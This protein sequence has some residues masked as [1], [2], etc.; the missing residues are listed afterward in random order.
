M[1]RLLRLLWVVMG[2]A[3]LVGAQAE[4]Q[5]RP[6][7]PSSVLIID[8]ERLYAESAFGKRVLAEQ[9]AEAAVLA[10]EYRRIEAELSEEE[11]MLTDK[12]SE[13]SPEDFRMVADAFDTRVEGI[14]EAQQQREND[15]IA[16]GDSERQRFFA[17]L[18]PV[19][20][21]VLRES[22]ALVVLEK[23]TVFA[24]SSALDVTDR[25]L[26]QADLI[27]GDGAAENTENGNGEN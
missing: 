27:I 24:S 25:V 11:Q 26:E 7:P 21:A 19:L 17:Q 15:L 22:G 4:A 3:F 13:M 18:G 1:T 5:S 9:Q 12:R 16:L 20:E 8:S 23:R 6:L 10:A 2:L 14:R